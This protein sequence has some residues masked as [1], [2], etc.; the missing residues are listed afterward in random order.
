MSQIVNLPGISCFFKG[1]AA[2]CVLQV[3]GMETYRHDASIL[4]QRFTISAC[5]MASRSE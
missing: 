1:I 3:S 4:T 2:R 5:G